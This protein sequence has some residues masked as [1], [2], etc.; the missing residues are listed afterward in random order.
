MKTTVEISDP[1]FRTVKTYCGDR[2]VSFREVVEKGLRL[3]VSERKN[4]P[5]FRL[6]PFGFKGDGQAM[7]DWSAIL[8]T[9]YEGR[10]GNPTSKKS[11]RKR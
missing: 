5:R 10:G 2:G 4:S 7:T 3:A 8:D 9:I 6:K 11:A 1:L